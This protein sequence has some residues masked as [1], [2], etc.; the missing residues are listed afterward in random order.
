MKT[1]SK[2]L[3]ESNLKTTTKEAANIIVEKEIDLGNFI[4]NFLEEKIYE[5]EDNDLV[6]KL[7]SESWWDSLKNT[8]GLGKQTQQTQQTQP[9]QQKQSRTDRLVSKNQKFFQDKSP[10]EAIKNALNQVYVLF[11]RNGYGE[12]YPDLLRK[13]L[14]LSKSVTARGIRQAAGMK[15][16]KN[17][18]NGSQSPAS[19]SP[20]GMSQY[21]TFSPGVVSYTAAQEKAKAEADRRAKEEEDRRAKEEEAKKRAEEEEANRKTTYDKYV[22]ANKTWDAFAR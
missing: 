10:Q 21:D 9:T 11:K 6:F 3:E 18:P 7:Y 20:A 1:F 16:D 8:F 22:A 15:Y 2:Y 12:F 5:S 4:Q 17:T 19:Q 13:I 14:E